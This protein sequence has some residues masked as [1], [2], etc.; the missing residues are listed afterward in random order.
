MTDAALEIN[1]NSSEAG[2]RFADHKIKAR[3]AIVD[4]LKSIP[5]I[6]DLD[7]EDVDDFLSDVSEK[8]YTISHSGGGKIP[9]TIIKEVIENLI[10]AEFKETSITI[11]DDGNKIIVSDQGPGIENKDKAMQPGFTTASLWM[12]KFIRGV[13]SGL[14]IVNETISFSGGAVEIEDNLRKGT[15]V[16]LSIKDIKDEKIDISERDSGSLSQPIEADKSREEDLSKIDV[17]LRQT[18]ILSLI[19]ELEEIGPSK[20]AKELGFSLS[21]SYRELVSLE[22]KDLI[23]QAD[24]GKRKL[25]GLGKKYLEYYTNSF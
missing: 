4:N 5:R 16:T 18:K 9:Y 14:P 8:V 21:T 17:T 15:V 7:Y 11:L 3:I 13:G 19:L 1:K 22:K 2:S 20:I 10:H 6:V 25:S 24:S 23:F 12:K